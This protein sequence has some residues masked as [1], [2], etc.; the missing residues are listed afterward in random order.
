M[1]AAATTDQLKLVALPSMTIIQV[2][3]VSIAACLITTCIPLRQIA[4]MSIVDSINI[5]E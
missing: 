2:A 4:K 1:I 5:V 3:F